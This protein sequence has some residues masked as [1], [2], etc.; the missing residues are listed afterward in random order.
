MARTT[1]VSN[2]FSWSQ[3]CSSH[4]SFTVDVTRFHV[5]RYRKLSWILCRQYTERVDVFLVQKFEV[6]YS[7]ILF[8]LGNPLLLIISN[9]SL[10]GWLMRLMIIQNIVIKRRNCSSF[11]TIFCYM[12]LDFHVKT[13]TRFSI[14]DKLLLAISE[15]EVVL[16]CFKVSFC[17]SVHTIA[18]LAYAIYL[19][20]FFLFFFLEHID[21]MA[22]IMASPACW[23][24][25]ALF[26]FFFFFI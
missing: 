16:D 11:S 7:V 13:G 2:K 4:R 8:Q 25:V 19:F 24:T 17:E 12:L 15:V 10:L 3:R 9:I 6:E 14:W 18:S 20:V 26:F 5:T 21:V 1:H 22:S 23:S